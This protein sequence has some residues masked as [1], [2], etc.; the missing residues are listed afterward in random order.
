MHNNSKRKGKQMNKVT[1]LTIVHT[2]GDNFALDTRELAGMYFGGD[3]KKAYS[4]LN[5]IGGLIGT[6]VNGEHASRKRV[7]GKLA[8]LVWQ[9]WEDSQGWT[10]EEAAEYIKQNGGDPMRE[11]A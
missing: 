5:S 1:A 10:M 7:D 2:I 4:V 6:D 9:V 3:L 11:V 8:T